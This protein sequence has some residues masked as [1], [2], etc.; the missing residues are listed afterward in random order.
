MYISK[1]HTFTFG[2]YGVQKQITVCRVGL[3]SCVRQLTGC[4]LNNTR[5]KD[6][7]KGGTRRDKEEREEREE[8]GNGEKD[9]FQGANAAAPGQTLALCDAEEEQTSREN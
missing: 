5:K 6:E 1:Q 2:F 8:E 7:R 4:S 9:S 3:R